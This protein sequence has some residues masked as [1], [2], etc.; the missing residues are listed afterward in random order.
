MFIFSLLKRTCLEIYIEGI[1]GKVV[2]PKKDHTRESLNRGH[3]PNGPF[4]GFV[5]LK[6]AFPKLISLECFPGGNTPLRACLP[7]LPYFTEISHTNL[8]AE[9]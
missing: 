7:P 4:F 1:S 3:C 5:W 9:R 8:E 2:F 6:C